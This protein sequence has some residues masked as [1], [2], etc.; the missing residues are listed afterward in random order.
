MGPER[1]EFIPMSGLNPPQI[2]TGNLVRYFKHESAI[3]EESATVGDDTKVWHFVHIRENARIGEAC[4]IAKDVY[5]DVNVVIGSRVK[6]QNGAS[7]YHGAI[8]EDDVFIGP[9]VMFTN[10]RL[11]RAF[12]HDYK[13]Y[14]TVIR[15]GASIGANATLTC[16][17]TIGEYAMVAAGSVVT[18]DVPPYTL[19]M[20]NPARPR[21]KIDKNGLPDQNSEE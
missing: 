11:P 9:G 2:D 7:L 21:Y 12:L 20:G 10:D 18:K 4:I 16:G 8:I 6:I 3:I 19:V 1:A 14:D 5:I 15:K 17:V 13:I